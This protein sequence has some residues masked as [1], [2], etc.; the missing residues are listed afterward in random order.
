MKT[1]NFPGC[2]YIK[3]GAR[4]NLIRVNKSSGFSRTELLVVLAIVVVLAAIITAGVSMLKARATGNVC[5]ANLKALGTAGHMYSQDNRD[6]FAYTDWNGGTI[7]GPAGWLYKVGADGIPDPTLPP[8][9][10]GSNAPCYTSG[11]YFK[12]MPNTKS[13]MCPVDAK[14]PSFLERKNKLSSY[15]MNGAPV[16]FPLARDNWIEGRLLARVNQATNPLC[17]LMWEPDAKDPTGSLEL[18]YNDGANF[19]GPN[20][21]SKY[22]EEIAPLHHNNGGEVL[23]IDGHVEFNTREQFH[24]QSMEAGLSLLWWSPFVRNGH[25]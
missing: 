8:Y 23:A 3:G 4:V 17:I 25:F 13:Y 19:P 16:G 7:G 24:F 2:G 5:L 15:V 20:I 12:Y 18:E 1:V 21:F 14:D 22:N 11:T 9:N 6:Y 10:T